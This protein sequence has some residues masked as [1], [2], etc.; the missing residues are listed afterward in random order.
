MFIQTDAAINHGN[1][2]GGLFNAQGELVGI[3]S[4]FF[5][6]DSNGIGFALPVSLVEF[7]S[8]RIIRD[9]QV[10]R[11]WLGVSSNTMSPY[12]LRALGIQ[13]KGGI[14]VTGITPDSPAEKSGLL[15]G[16]VILSING[17]NIGDLAVFVRWLSRMEPGTD[18]VMDVLR[19]DKQGKQSQFHIP[20]T[21]VV[22]PER[23]SP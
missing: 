17:K 6:E 9:G 10:I 18:I 16:D 4:S 8:S 2:G 20:V 21:L 5:S 19:V 22:K 3:N 1:S 15:V 11:G 12:D 23:L 14:R 13:D 7:V